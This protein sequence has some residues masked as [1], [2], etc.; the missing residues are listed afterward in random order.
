MDVPLAVLAEAA[1]VSRE[2]TL[3]IL[4]IFGVIRA[5]AFPARHP[6]AVLVIQLRAR[7]SERGQPVRVTIR[8]MDEDKVLAEIE[9]EFVIPSPEG[10]D[11]IRINQLFHLRMLVLPKAGEYAFHILVN[12][13]EKATVPFRALEMPSQPAA[14]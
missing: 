7:P 10:S 5:S 3:N 9:G 2:N 8:M 11:D 6:A 13:D 1:N 14:K 4:G 12:G